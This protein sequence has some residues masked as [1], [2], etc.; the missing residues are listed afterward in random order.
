MRVKF[1]IFIWFGVACVTRETITL[2]S[3]VSCPFGTSTF[4]SKKCISLLDFCLSQKKVLNFDRTDCDQICP[5]GTSPDSYGDKCASPPTTSGLE[6][7]LKLESVKKVLEQ[8]KSSLADGDLVNKLD[9]AEN[10]ILELVSIEQIQDS[11][12][13][14]KVL[15]DAITKMKNIKQRLPI[16]KQLRETLSG[17]VIDICND[18]IE[19][20]NEMKSGQKQRFRSFLRK[21]RFMYTLVGRR[22]SELQITRER[23]KEDIMEVIAGVSVTDTLIEKATKNLGS[24]EKIDISP[25]TVFS[26]ATE[27]F[28]HFS[29]ADTKK[30]VKEAIF[31][32]L[33]NI[34][35]LINTAKSIIN[36]LQSASTRRTLKRNIEGVAYSLSPLITY[37]QEEATKIEESKRNVE[38]A[39]K[40]LEK[41][42]KKLDST[43]FLPFW[44]DHYLNDISFQIED[45]RLFAKLL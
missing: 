7:I 30:E 20:V 9:N 37:F 44:T 41:E 32:T 26:K 10:S 16:I 42:K 19:R 40:E 1:A 39:I 28:G 11:Q 29:S 38:A 27:I 12:D 43:E 17:K 8:E 33:E 15:T 24:V 5:S 35:A 6:N 23:S 25:N 13:V 36:S 14:K 21:I 34:P 31:K 3:E 18:I 22:V 45:I 2:S 4:S